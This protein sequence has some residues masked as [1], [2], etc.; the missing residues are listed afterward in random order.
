MKHLF[1]RAAISLAILAASGTAAAA[2]ASAS[3]RVTSFEVAVSGGTLSWADGGAF[4][5]LFAQS[6]EAGGLA[7]VQLD[8]RTG[9][10]L[11]DAVIATQVAHASA[12]VTGAADGRIAG[13]VSAT[14]F[15]IDAASQPHAGEARASQSH[16]FS[17]SQP[18]TVTFTV[19]YLLDAAA[20]GG[21][22]FYTAGYA[23]IGFDAGAYA[24]TSGGSG[25]DE[26]FSSVAGG[27]SGR[28]SF[29]VA[30]DGAG[31]QGWFDLRGNAFASAI[32]T[33][34]PEPSEW[35]MMVAGLG[36]LAAW[37]G[38]TQRRAEAAR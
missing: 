14:A 11:D 28:F 19:D 24:N 17:L 38:R 16:V 35:A 13:S 30:L 9:T 10:R 1:P 4:Q 22:G 34:V 33:P 27:R 25:F 3:F 31:D 7:D 6:A 20:P 36:L 12:G 21:D 5:N 2:D 8:G 18:G 23:S 37:R 32:A 29:V 15:A 26:A